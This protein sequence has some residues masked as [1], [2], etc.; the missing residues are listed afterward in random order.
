MNCNLLIQK[1]SISCE[2]YLEIYKNRIIPESEKLFV[3][4]FLFPILGN[5][6]FHNIRLLIQKDILD[7]LTLE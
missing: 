4:E 2:E 6:L 5:E 1:D 3:R 7:K